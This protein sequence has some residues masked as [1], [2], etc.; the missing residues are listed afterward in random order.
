[1][2]LLTRSIETRTWIRHNRAWQSAQTSPGESLAGFKWSSSPGDS[3]FIYGYS[4]MLPFSEKGHEQ[5]NDRE[6]GNY[7]I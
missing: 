7:F 1:M 4:H 6:E 5:K 3:S 2:V